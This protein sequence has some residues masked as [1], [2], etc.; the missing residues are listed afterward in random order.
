MTQVIIV[1]DEPLAAQ[2]LS[3]Q[4]KNIDTEIEILA[5]LG[6]VSTTVEFLSSR[7]V[8]LIFLDIH[9]GDDLSFSIFEKMQVSAPVIFTT[10]YDQY[11]IKAFKVNSIDYLLKPVNKTDLKQ[12]ITKF[13]EQR[14]LQQPSVDYQSLIQTLRSRAVESYQSRFLVYKGDKVKSIEV[15]TIAYF[16]AEGKYVY[17]V[18]KN[19]QEF[20]VDYTL[21][22]LK[23]CLD[24]K[25]FFRI[26]R[27]FVIHIQAIQEMTTYTKGRLKINLNPPAKKDAIVSIERASAFK[28]WLNK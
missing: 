15:D 4:L 2:K 25:L 11:A 22:K 3:R 5:T 10:A 1:E 19:G 28:T 21:D 14:K 26:N 23:T 16:F 13:Y 6:S 9:L 18:D 8:D 17:L 24:P 7:A 27:Q 12:A 20:L